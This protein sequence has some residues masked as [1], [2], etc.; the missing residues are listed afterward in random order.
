MAEHFKYYPSDEEV[1][2]P[3]NARYSYPSQANKATKMTPRIPPKNGASFGPGQIIR[4]EFP[5]QGYVNPLNTLLQFD[6]V[7]YAPVVASGAWA[8]R[9]QN[10]IQCIFNRVRLLYGANPQ[11]DLLQYGVLVRCLTE[12]TATS[13]MNSID[14]GSIADGIGGCYTGEVGSSV[15]A[16]ITSATGAVSSNVV[17]LSSA[18][19]T[20]AAG[21]ALG[22]YV[23]VSGATAATSGSINGTYLITAFT[24]GT[25]LSYNS[26]A[27]GTITGTISTT[28]LS[29]ARGLLN[30]RQD[31]IQGLEGNFVTGLTPSLA[32][33]DNW[34]QTYGN[35]SGLVPNNSNTLIPA[36]CPS[37]TTAATI[38][39]GANCFSVRRYMINFALGLFTQ[40][41]LIPTKYMASQLAIEITL[42]AANECIYQSL[43]YSASNTVQ[44]TYAVGNVAL[45]PEIIEFDDTYDEQFLKGLESGGVPIKFSTWHYFQFTTQGASSLQLQITERS[46]SVKGIFSVQRR[47]PPGFQYDS[48]ACF[49]DTNSSINSASG[50]TMQQYQYR[51]GG[52]YFPASP[53]QLTAPGGSVSNGGAEA[54]IELCKFLNIVGDSRLKTNTTAFNW[55]VPAVINQSV[56]ILP[57][58]DFSFAHGGYSSV[59]IPYV[60]PSESFASCFVGNTPSSM[61]ACSIN[62]ETSNG[63]EISGLNAEEQSDISFNVMWSSAQ[64]TGFSIE[65]FTYVDVMWV[66]RPNNYLDLIQ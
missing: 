4:L 9:F 24:S 64:A 29:L 57:E 38:S 20:T 27:A 10:N 21:Y 49:F 63:I 22:G 19:I 16:T 48:H 32:M 23:T 18:G 40:D 35:G 31:Q 47:N 34:L 44:P 28:P 50:S 60:F 36:G 41:K 6:V 45:I 11:E 13:Q 56:N 1:V 25:S 58:Y 2:T 65:C 53:V 39:T 30:T 43:G 8:V 42:A 51:I 17:T 33:D 66:L 54:F 55:A 62:F 14:Q 37:I 3:W 7:L 26:V 59:G 12:W 52:R 5:A 61:F 15:G 46:R